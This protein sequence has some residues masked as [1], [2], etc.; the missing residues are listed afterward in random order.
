MPAIIVLDANVLIPNALC[1]LLQSPRTSRTPRRW[2]GGY[3][4]RAA[5]VLAEAYAFGEVGYAPQA[6]D[7]LHRRLSTDNRRPYATSLPPAATSLP[8]ITRCGSH[9][10]DVN[11]VLLQ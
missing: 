1:D 2:S 8:R 5:N 11:L 7:L 10:K 6:Y 9:G 3:R 4:D